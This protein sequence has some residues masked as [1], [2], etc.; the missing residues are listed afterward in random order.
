M[1]CSPYQ[2]VPFT[3]VPDVSVDDARKGVKEFDDYCER[4]LLALV[5]LEHQYLQHEPAIARIARLDVSVMFKNDKWGY[6]V[7]EVTRCPGFRFFSREHG[8]L[9]EFGLVFKEYYRVSSST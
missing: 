2:P 6:F 8:N 1:S 3:D 5:E 9:D 4:T 7:N